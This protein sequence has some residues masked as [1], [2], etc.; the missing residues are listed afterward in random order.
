MTRPYC[1]ESITERL[2][3]LGLPFAKHVARALVALRTAKKISL[4]HIVQ[5]MPGK[6]NPEANPMQLRRCLDHPKL[7]ATVWAKVLAA[8]LPKGKWVLALDRTEWKRGR[9]CINVLVLSVVAYGS[10][11]PLLWTVMPKCGARDTNERIE[12]MTRFIEPFGPERWHFLTAGYPHNVGGE[13]IGDAWM[14]WLIQR[15]FD[16]RIR[17]KAVEWFL[18]PDGRDLQGW[19]WFGKRAC[20]CK[21][22]RMQLWNQQVYVAGKYL[23]RTHKEN[24]DEYRIVISNTSGDLMA[25]YRLPPRG[26]PKIETLFQAGT[27][28]V[29]ERSW[30][31]F[32]I[33][34]VESG[35]SSLWLVW[36]S[37]AWFLRVFD[38]GGCAGG[39][40]PVAPEESW[41]SC[42]QL[43]PSWSGLPQR[44]VVVL[45]GS[46]VCPSFCGGP[47]ALGTADTTS[48][49]G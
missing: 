23:Y 29:G 9:T 25:D 46:S 21:P 49:P 22:P 11:V 24:R 42:G 39:V 13:F 32:G 20:K 8:L 14:G 48:D 43:L 2:H 40:R 10:A 27:H 17:V 26:Y 4:Y 41:S 6:T 47:I 31:R 12:L 37:G 28:T 33:V 19:E 36:F 30:L 1:I 7:D 18:H 15:G 16:F 5:L 44:F 3:A 35:S 45:V 34:P 38:G